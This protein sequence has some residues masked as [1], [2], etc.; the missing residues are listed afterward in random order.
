[1][2]A[3]HTILRRTDDFER[4]CGC[5]RMQRAVGVSPR[6][7]YRSVKFA[8]SLALKVC[9]AKF[10]RTLVRR[11]PQL[12]TRA[13]PQRADPP[14]RQPVRRCEH[15]RLRMH[16]SNKPVACSNPKRTVTRN[17]Q[18][19]NVVSRKRR[20]RNRGSRRT[21]ENL[22]RDTVKPHQPCFGP[23]P[24]K[25]IG[26]LRKRVDGVLRQTILY[27]PRLPGVVGQGRRRLERAGAAPQNQN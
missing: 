27:H 8:T 14:G 12:S 17:Q 5:G 20:S 1:L 4:A 7:P 6:R 10:R 16:P 21:I 24:H 9:A 2:P 15:R 3:T 19:A 18:A 25:A 13:F 23:K 11:Y 26:R 22:E